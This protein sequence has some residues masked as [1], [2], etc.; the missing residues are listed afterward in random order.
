M[1]LPPDRERVRQVLSETIGLLC[2][3]GLSFG[4][5]L[6]VD[7]LIGIT[8]DHKDV[9][10]ISIK[11]TYDSEK[12]LHRPS[13]SIAAQ[14]PSDCIEKNCCTKPDSALKCNCPSS[15]TNVGSGAERNSSSEKQTTSNYCSSAQSCSKR[16]IDRNEFL[17]DQRKRARVS[18]G[19][20]MD[21][22][23]QVEPSLLAVV[24]AEP[25]DALLDTDT[26]GAL[27][28]AK[29]PHSSASQWQCTSGTLSGAKSPNCSTSQGQCT[30]AS[31]SLVNSELNSV[32]DSVRFRIRAPSSNGDTT[33]REPPDVSCIARESSSD[34]LPPS[35]CM[36]RNKSN[37]VGSRSASDCNDVVSSF[38][39][40]N[41][42]QT[43]SGH[44][45][46]NSNSRKSSSLLPSNVH[47]Q[48]LSAVSRYNSQAPS[49][50]HSSH[51]VIEKPADS[52]GPSDGLTL[53]KA[54]DRAE[55][56]A[57]IR[58]RK[59]NEVICSSDVESA[60][61]DSEVIC[62]KEEIPYLPFHSSASFLAD[63][64]R[65]S[66]RNSSSTRL[67]DVALTLS[68]ADSLNLESLSYDR[69]AGWNGVQNNFFH[70]V[71][72]QPKDT[73]NHDNALPSSFTVCFG[74][75]VL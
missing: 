70:S 51:S 6:S 40:Q 13:N 60:S 3:N 55:S 34:D 45:E 19:T 74:K 24:K 14:M 58:R 17:G 26:L 25:S 12:N 39:E 20:S 47:M 1:T 59:S 28:G 32:I 7:A 49:I 63:D 22:S 73:W 52:D 67:M 2:R 68:S 46:A 18:V 48:N 44:P 38:A 8:V 23:F 21:D 5:Q 42:S 33:G 31:I 37:E 50:C 75:S 16:T 30:S 72:K 4:C 56:Q 53:D 35:N 36:H 64:T 15:M 54:P 65:P 57:G 61:S 43:V 41:V 71:R 9:F 29:S 27:S 62:I 11:D 69:S 10:L 66:L